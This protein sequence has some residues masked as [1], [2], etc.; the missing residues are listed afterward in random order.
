M[1]YGRGVDAEFAAESLYVGDVARLGVTQ[2]DFRA[3]EADL[4]ASR[5]HNLVQ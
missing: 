5:V 4:I 1:R 3:A 2:G